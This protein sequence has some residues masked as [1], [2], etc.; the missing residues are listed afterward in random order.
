MQL[1]RELWLLIKCYPIAKGRVL[2]DRP[3][4]YPG[5]VCHMIA[6][7]ETRTELVKRGIREDSQITGAVVMIAVGLAYLLNR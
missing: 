4:K 6:Y 5:A 2:V 1:L 7:N 3:E